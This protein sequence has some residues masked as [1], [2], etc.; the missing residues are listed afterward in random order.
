MMTM[1][2]IHNDQK[3]APQTT[4]KRS[5]PVTRR[6]VGCAYVMMVIIY[7]DDDQRPEQ[8]LSDY[9]DNADDG[10][11]RPEKVSMMMS[12]QTTSC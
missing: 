10:D 8:G 9:D 3:F 7:D 5:T 2:M 1:T 6:K 12:G 4:T 11:K